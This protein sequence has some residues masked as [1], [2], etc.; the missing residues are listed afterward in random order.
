[1]LAYHADA[2]L[3][4]DVVRSAAAEM[5]GK[6]V[7]GRCVLGRQ[8]RANS[9]AGGFDAPGIIGVPLGAARL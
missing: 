2:L 9:G 4:P 7:N 8:K 1:M 5:A 3:K 6:N